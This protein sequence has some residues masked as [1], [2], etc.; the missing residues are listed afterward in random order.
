MKSS[1]SSEV[2]EHILE[3]IWNKCITYVF[4]TVSVWHASDPPLTFMLPLSIA[5]TIG[6][7]QSH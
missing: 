3:I 7:Q 2:V 5:S 6:H 4:D 1:D